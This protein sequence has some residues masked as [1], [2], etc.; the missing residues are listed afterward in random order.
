MSS[1][2]LYSL[3]SPA[4]TC[5]ARIYSSPGAA[6][7]CC[8]S[9]CSWKRTANTGCDTGRRQACCCALGSQKASVICLSISPAPSTVLAPQADGRAAKD[10]SDTHIFT[11]P[12]STKMQQCTHCCATHK[13]SSLCQGCGTV[14]T[15]HHV[16]CHWQCTSDCMCGSSKHLLNWIFLLNFPCTL[17]AQ[18][19]QNQAP[20]SI[21]YENSEK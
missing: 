9:S 18:E 2:C 5:P 19:V 11:T 7:S 21:G 15:G 3:S 20:E 17:I 4:A 10:N 1:P 6:E 12:S 14:P 13:S 16:T 8:I